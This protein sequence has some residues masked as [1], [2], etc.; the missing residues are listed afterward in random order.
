V[1]QISIVIYFIYLFLMCA[2]TVSKKYGC[3]KISDMYRDTNMVGKNFG[4]VIFQIF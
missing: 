4:D 1:Y 2:N 3:I